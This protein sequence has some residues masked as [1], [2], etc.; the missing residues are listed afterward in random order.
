MQ[1]SNPRH[2]VTPN[3]RQ[4]VIDDT[5]DVDGHAAVPDVGVAIVDDPAEPVVR[6]ALANVVVGT[7]ARH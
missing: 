5:E 1:N 2:S 3:E 4:P 6:D 7:R